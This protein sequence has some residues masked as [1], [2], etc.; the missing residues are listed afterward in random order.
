MS[1]IVHLLLL[2]FVGSLHGQQEDTTWDAPPSIEHTPHF[3]ELERLHASDLLSPDGENLLLQK[4]RKLNV[5]TVIEGV[6]DHWPALTL[7]NNQELFIHK[8]GY[9]PIHDEV[10]VNHTLDVAQDGP[11]VKTTSTGAT[12][13]HFLK[14]LSKSKP[15]LAS[16]SSSSEASQLVDPYSE[17]FL[18]QRAPQ[19]KSLIR[20]LSEDLIASSD[21]DYDDMSPSN[22]NSKSSR[23]TETNTDSKKNTKNKK[24]KNK[25]NKKGTP[26]PTPPLLA[27]LG[28]GFSKWHVLSIGGRSGGLPPHKHTASW[29]GLIVGRKHWTF[30]HPDELSVPAIEASLSIQGNESVK[31]RS[32]LDLYAQAALNSPSRW[33]EDVWSVLRGDKVK[34][35][36]DSNEDK[37]ED[38]DQ[39]RGSKKESKSKSKVLQ[40][41]QEVGEVIYIPHLWWHATGNLGDVIGVGGQADGF[42]VPRALSPQQRY[43]GCSMALSQGCSGL[44][45]HE[46]DEEGDEEERGDGGGYSSLID[47][48]MK[49]RNSNSDSDDGSACSPRVQRGLSRRAYELE[50]LNVKHILG[51]AE[52]MLSLP[53]EYVIAPK[54]TKKNKKKSKNKNN[55]YADTP[56]ISPSMP[57]PLSDVVT[58]LASCADMVEDQVHKGHMSRVSGGHMIGRIGIWLD[59]APSLAGEALPPMTREDKTRSPSTFT[60]YQ[61][62]ADEATE[63][64]YR[65]TIT[66]LRNLYTELLEDDNGGDGNKKT[67]LK[68]SQKT[69]KKKTKKNKKKKKTNSGT[70]SEL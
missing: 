14:S 28:V 64:F 59:K 39:S 68:S 5:P 66:E 40:C 47:V 53:Y 34:D 8:F 31:E 54:K 18:F 17:P 9:I 48:D 49:G 62:V 27:P 51:N 41:I 70:T 61:W 21:N 20:F 63:V 22:S 12:L 50:P 44:L 1:L 45:R 11:N 2:T 16:S 29:L 33:G 15:N 43:S 25:K 35:S 37:V 67:N 6:I 36:T 3:C 23:N 32:A 24:N 69:K 42:Q 55:P 57:N 65:S 38:K 7:W 56:Q 13:G 52:K 10:L 46:E 4:L 30:L 58:F 19:D 26:I 60:Q